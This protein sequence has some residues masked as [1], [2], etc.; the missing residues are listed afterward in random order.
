MH[1]FVKFHAAAASAA[2]ALALAASPASAALTSTG[3]SGGAGMTSPSFLACS[4]AWEGTNMNQEADVAAVLAGWGTGFDFVGSS[5]ASGNGPF[6]GNPNGNTGT[7]TFDQ[8]VAGTFAIALKAGNA[9]SLYLFDGGQAGITS[10]DY[11]TLGVQVN[12]K[13]I[14]AGLSHATLYGGTPPVPEP[15]TYALMLAGLGLVGFMARRRR[16]AQQS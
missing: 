11:N 12:R 9:F 10:I 2:L 4:G 1:R 5:D 13:G 8:A 7:L 16:S 6:T 14:G 3:L 15:E